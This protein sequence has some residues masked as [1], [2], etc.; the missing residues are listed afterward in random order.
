MVETTEAALVQGT[1]EAQAQGAIADQAQ[2]ATG[3]AQGATGATEAT[4]VIEALTAK[5]SALEKDNRS[6]RQREAQREA[7]EK[8][9]AAA[10]MSEAER[11]TAENAEL[12]A[13]LATTTQRE[14]EQSLRLNA[15]TAAQR[16]GY[17]SLDRALDHLLANI[18]KVEFDEEG[19]PKN[20][21]R[22][23]TDLAKSDPALVV[24]PDFGGGQRGAPV[25]QGNDMNTL[26]RAAA[27]R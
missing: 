12:R 1:D 27:R 3:D 18:G 13:A 16:L 17:R 5:V 8:A 11:L 7:A 14:K 26:I 25:P 2:G 23:L 19:Q 20:V 9:R 24:T 6:Y 21:E 22:M 4:T 10:E 15:A